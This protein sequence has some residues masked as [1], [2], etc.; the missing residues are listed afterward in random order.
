MPLHL[1]EACVHEVDLVKVEITEQVEIRRVN[2]YCRLKHE[3][4]TNILQRVF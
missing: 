1:F 2:F 4:R 3:T